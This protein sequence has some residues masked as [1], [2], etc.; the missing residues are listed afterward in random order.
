MGA[1]LLA[2]GAGAP[3]FAQDTAAAAV[4][5]PPADTARPPT[6]SAAAPGAP[7]TGQNGV[8]RDSVRPD[9]VRVDTA[10]ARAAPP[11]TPV[12]SALAHACRSAAGGP[13]DLLT[14]KFRPTATAAEREAAARQVGGTLLEQ[15]E[16]QA[17][18]AWY[19]RLPPEAVDRSVADQLIML[20]PVLEVGATRCPS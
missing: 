2:G 6:D 13:P 1:A 3:A 5:A 16:H 8:R 12:D 17:P 15:S 19:L 10:A 11:P 14:V 7:S 20:Q 18:G 9:T 4:T